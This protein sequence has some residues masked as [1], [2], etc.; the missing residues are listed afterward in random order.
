MVSLQAHFQKKSATPML[1]GIMQHA[2]NDIFTVN[3]GLQYG[4]ITSNILE[5]FVA[6]IYFRKKMVYAE[7]LMLKLCR[8]K[9]SIT[10]TT[11]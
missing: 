8:K 11:G 3:V 7:L 5:T 9:Y 1:E 10:C 4:N 6:F 2:V